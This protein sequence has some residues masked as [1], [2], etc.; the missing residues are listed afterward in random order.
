[1]SEIDWINKELV[2]LDSP[3]VNIKDNDFY[4]RTGQD[5][6]RTRGFKKMLK[7]LNTREHIKEDNNKNS[8]GDLHL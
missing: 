8:K 6:Y 7:E 4:I 1:M 5:I 2:L 3:I